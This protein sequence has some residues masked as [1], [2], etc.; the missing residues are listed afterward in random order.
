MPKL[1]SWLLMPL[2]WQSAAIYLE[3][4]ISLTIEGC[5]APSEDSCDS[6]HNV[7][8]VPDLFVSTWPS[9]RSTLI[10]RFLPMNSLSANATD[11]QS[12]FRQ[13][14]TSCSPSFGA[15]IIGSNDSHPTCLAKQA[16]SWNQDV[17]AFH[18]SVYHIVI[19]LFFFGT[20]SPSAIRGL[21]ATRFLEA[22]R[23]DGPITKDK[24]TTTDTAKLCLFALESSQDNP[25]EL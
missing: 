23:I 19:E 22:G 4:G 7:F 6:G 13:L 17:G 20:D 3:I 10:H 24:R 2:S 12:T 15:H 11:S 25:E 8:F 5:F 9:H 14:C 18:L 21:T 1:L 16:A